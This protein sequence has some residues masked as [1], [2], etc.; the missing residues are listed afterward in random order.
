MN[1][2]RSSAAL[3]SASDSAKSMRCC[4]RGSYC[5][6]AEGGSLKVS[7]GYAGTPRSLKVMEA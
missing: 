5:W 1:F 3:A 6:S 4:S 7:D 2:R